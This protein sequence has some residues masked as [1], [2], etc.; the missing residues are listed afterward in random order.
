MNLFIIKIIPL[1]GSILL[2]FSCKST[3][4]APENFTRKQLVFGS[5][6]GITGMVKQHALLEDGYLFTKTNLEDTYTYV[7]KVS[8]RKC[9]GYFNQSQLLNIKDVAF[10]HPGNRYF[11]LEYKD[12]L[13]TNRITW[14]D[15]QHTPPEEITDLY[16]QLNQLIL[17]KP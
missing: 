8:K 6:G 13:S 17:S 12:T 3:K 7:S 14:G 9:K 2:F 16:D 5:G 10:S 11:F 15:G 1:L 4:P